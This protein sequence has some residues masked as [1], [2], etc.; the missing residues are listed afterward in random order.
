MKFFKRYFNIISLTLLIFVVILFLQDI[1]YLQNFDLDNKKAR[2]LG[3]LLLNYNI[4]NKI[5]TL[6]TDP[7]KYREDIL[8]YLAIIPKSLPEDKREN[9]A[10]SIKLKKELAKKGMKLANEDFKGNYFEIMKID[11]IIRLIDLVQFARDDEGYISPLDEY[12][13][14]LEEVYGLSKLDYDFT[15]PENEDILINQLA[16]D[17]ECFIDYNYIRAM[18][19]VLHIEI[20]EKMILSEDGNKNFAG[21]YM[22][23]S[24]QDLIRK[25]NFHLIFLAF[26]FIITVLKDKK[27]NAPKLDYTMNTSLF[28]M[29]NKYIREFLCLAFITVI[30][31]VGLL[32][33]ANLGGKGFSFK[34]PVLTIPENYELSDTKSLGAWAQEGFERI[35]G[36]DV[37]D[38]STFFADDT[39]YAAG[40]SD[41]LIMSY[42]PQIQEYKTVFIKAV[43]LDL[44]RILLVA[45]AVAFIA[46]VFNKRWVV[47]L[48]TTA[49]AILFL[50]A[51]NLN[52]IFDPFSWPVSTSIVKG[53]RV[54]KDGRLSF[55]RAMIILS[56][57]TVVIYLLNLLVLKKKKA[58]V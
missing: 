51:Y 24:Q 26:A 29:T 20:K 8:N 37:V 43:V 56:S 7:D 33:A 1:K 41:V 46:S 6:N 10:K 49:L 22:L 42:R 23:F 53:A 35:T 14:E 13:S 32:L 58:L 40:R 3:R 31:P 2:Y 54:L 17:K 16:Q 36:Y 57:Y 11:N 34:A 4:N 39:T 27:Y 30:L 47:L 44:L 52:S 50:N 21:V 45:V 28:T 9:Y 19:D 18:F 25:N 38:Y 55:N 15:A 12:G 48:L 5:E